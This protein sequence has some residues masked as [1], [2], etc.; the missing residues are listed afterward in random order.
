VAAKLV[1]H[2][3]HAAPPAAISHSEKPDKKPQNLQ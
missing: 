1:Q 2:Q 3:H